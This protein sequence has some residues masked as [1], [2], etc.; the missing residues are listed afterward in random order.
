MVSCQSGNASLGIQAQLSASESCFP[1]EL[2][3][4]TCV[5]NVQASSCSWRY[6]SPSLSLVKDNNLA[7]EVSLNEINEKRVR[8]RIYNLIHH[9]NVKMLSLIQ[10][11]EELVGFFNTQHPRQPSTPFQHGGCL[12]G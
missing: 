1:G 10:N 11:D 6:S 9:R 8:R 12:P 5:F 7:W 3:A 4:S 2:L